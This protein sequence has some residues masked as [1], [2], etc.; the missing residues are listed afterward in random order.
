MMMMMMMSRRTNLS[1]LRKKND[2]D[3][4]WANSSSY[5]ELLLLDKRITDYLSG[6]FY[7]MRIPTSNYIIRRFMLNFVFIETEL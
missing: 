3:S 1:S 4:V 5:T 2:W 6:M 7:I